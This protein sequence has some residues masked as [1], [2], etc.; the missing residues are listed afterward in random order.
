VALGRAIVR[1]PRV[2]LMDEPL[3]NLDAKLRVQM[4]TEISK[5]HQRLQ[6]T[7]IYVTHD[8]TEAM[9][10][11]DR[12]VVMKDGLIQQVATPHEV[13]SHPNN[14]FV[15]GF[16]GLPAMNFFDGELLEEGNAI[17]FRAPGLNI[18]LQETRYSALREAGVIGKSVIFGI[19]P[20][21][22]HDSTASPVHNVAQIEARIE[23]VE[24]MGFEM[25]VHG[26]L[27]GQAITA[28]FDARPD[29]QPGAIAKFT[30]DMDKFH[31]FSKVTENTVF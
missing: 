12:I 23:V 15:A 6:T 2:F 13:Y 17:Y 14:V 19:R 25:Y 9:T 11:A 20:E 8:Q 27:A 16:I 30:F 26:K 10:M 7:L 18:H 3:S 31:S 28:R 24:L 29:I 4:R 21:N 1:E 5:L 22:I